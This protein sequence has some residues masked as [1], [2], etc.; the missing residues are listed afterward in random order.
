[1]TGQFTSMSRLLTTIYGFL[2]T[3]GFCLASPDSS[4]GQSPFDL[5]R[6]GEEHPLAP[7]V[8]VLENVG[9][10]IDQNVRD[11]SCILTKQE[12]LDGELGEVQHIFMKVRSEPFS[13]YMKFQQPYAGREVLYVEGMN[14]GDLIALEGGWKRKIMSPVSLDPE[15]MIA[16]RGQ[17]YPITSVGLRN[18]VT[19]FL[20]RSKKDLKFA[21]CEVSFDPNQTVE[22]RPATLIQ[23]TH[24][25]PRQDF[26]CHVS[27]MFL[28]NEL[29][30]PLHYDAYMWPRTPG[31]RPPLEESYTYRNLKLNN[32]FGARDFEKDNPE[33]F[34]Q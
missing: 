4:S 8:R 29:R 10:H 3:L 13:V 28:D 18:L 17:K 25:Q 6:R 22:G 24:P 26:Y 15:G 1:M 31:E 12:R 32:G 14:D 11:Y 33:I 30:V 16:M 2:L 7:V 5:E 9:Q 20:E 23:V 19:K 34:K 27:R 21:E